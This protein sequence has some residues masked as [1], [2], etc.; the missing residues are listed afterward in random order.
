MHVMSNK[1][2]LDVGSDQGGATKASVMADAEA[3]QACYR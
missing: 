1:S 2:L 3:L